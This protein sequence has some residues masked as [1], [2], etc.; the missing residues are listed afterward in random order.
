MEQKNYKN[1]SLAK[2][3]VRVYDLGTTKLH[4]YQTNDPMNDEVFI[5]EKN[6][7]AI[8]IEAPCFVDNIVELTEYIQSLSVQVEAQI[9]SYHMAGATFLPTVPV[10]ATQKADE[11]GH[12]GGGKMLVDNFAVAFGNAFDTSIHT[13][14]HTI[15]A[16]PLKIAGFTLDILPTQDAFD[17]E[18]PSLGLVYVHMLGHDCHSIVAGADHADALISQLK[19]LITRGFDFILTSHYTPETLQDAQEKVDYLE[20]V[21]TIAASSP[22]AAAFKE[23]VLEKYPNYTGGN[24]L[25]MTAGFFFSA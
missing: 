12:S 19:D 22:D 16:G 24:Y 4:A 8:V 1:I 2:G 5:L 23:S 14:T 3:A 17:I 13:V 21:K 6:G 20:S 7:S 15:T 9:L 10:Y 11:Y 18:I 25:D